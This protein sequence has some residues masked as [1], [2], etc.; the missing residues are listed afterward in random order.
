MLEIALAILAVLGGFVILVWAAGQFVIGASA[1]AR[2]FG[3][4]PLIIGLTIVSF[5]TSAPEIFTSAIASLQGNPGLGIGNAVG[6]NIANI[7]LVLGI[8][9]LIAPIRIQSKLVKREY[10]VLFAITILATLLIMDNR[11]DIVDGIILLI[12][13]GAMLYWMVHIG[14]K[15]RHKDILEKEFEAEIPKSM[16]MGKGIF[17]LS[18]GLVGLV[19]GSKIL[20]WGSVLI[21]GKMGL[22]D[23]VIGLTI[24]A[25]GTSLPELAASVASVLKKEHDLAI[26]NIVG[27][28][29]FNTLAVLPLPGLIAPGPISTNVLMRDFPVMIGFTILLIV[30]SLNFGKSNTIGR[31]KGLLLLAIFITYQVMLFVTKDQT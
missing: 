29:M 6:S 5:A 13:L 21:A 1:T 4:S 16:P 19:L 3:V 2:N 24:V 22:S 8:T 17:L 23:L 14:L 20:V 28:N 18:I 25:I 12:G 7:G 30:F 27:S 31:Y 26:G 9:V 15:E 11:L 10:P